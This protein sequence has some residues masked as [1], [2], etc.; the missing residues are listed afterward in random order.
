MTP[1]RTFLPKERAAC[2]EG[3]NFMVQRLPS[4]VLNHE[5]RLRR[6]N[7]RIM[8]GSQNGMRNTAVTD[9]ITNLLLAPPIEQVSRVWWHIYVYEANQPVGT[10]ELAAQDASLWTFAGNIYNKVVE[11]R[12]KQPPYFFTLSYVK[13]G[14]LVH[15]LRHVRHANHGSGGWERVH[16]ETDAPRNPAEPLSVSA[17]EDLCKAMVKYPRYHNQMGSLRRKA[18]SCFKKQIHIASHATCFCVCCMGKA[19][20][21][22]RCVVKPTSLDHTVVVVDGA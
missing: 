3:L 4:L 9:T 12:Q 19:K 1:I 11:Q 16:N 15:T 6:V 13:N 10:T 2:D 18:L 20:A 7:V 22:S 14:G 8:M 5:Y 17:V 21:W